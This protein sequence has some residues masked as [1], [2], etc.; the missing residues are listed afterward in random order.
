M[1][2][3]VLINKFDISVGGSGSFVFLGDLTGNG[4][5]DFLVA[6]PDSTYDDR[7]YPHQ[8]QSLTAYDIKGNIVWQVGTPQEGTK[9]AG[10]D[11]PVQICD[12][13]GDGF[14]EVLCVMDKKFRILN[15][16]DGSLKKEFDLP[17]EWAHDC[18]IVANLTGGDYPSD[19]ILKNRYHKMWAMDKDFNVLWTHEGNMGHFPWV[20]DFDGDG[21]DEV[22]AGYTMLDSD[23]TPQWSCHDLDDHCDAL[24]VGNVKPECDGVQMV[25]G[26]SVTVLYDTKGKEIWRYSGSKESQHVALGRYNPNS[27]EVLVAGLDRVVRGGPNAEDALFVLN[28]NGEEIAREKRDTI[29]WL[30]I[31]HTINNYMGDNQD[32]ILAFRRG[33]GIMPTLYN[34]K[35]EP[36]VSFP[37]D[38]YVL[39]ADV[40]GENKE[41]VIIYSNGE[42]AIF[43][44]RM[45]DID[46]EPSGKPL[47]QP[48]RLSHQT[49]YFGAQMPEIS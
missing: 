17:N 11:I 32:Y 29:G 7:Y 8:I 36:V 10:S 30:T 2:E 41:D 5:V 16:R 18:I 20:Y 34:H 44:S 33:G 45:S 4:R 40:F 21:R 37:K 23:G 42:L 24:W 27:D 9:T 39:F 15:G 31:I 19:I 43:G 25:I 38:G 48:K 35:L 6:Q 28:S 13:D 46:K 3:P 14:N 26:G 12:I 47:N 22:M 49:V 1:S